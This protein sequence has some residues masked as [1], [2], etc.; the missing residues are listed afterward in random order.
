MYSAFGELTY[1]RVATFG[2]RVSTARV[3]Q[4]ALEGQTADCTA[5]PPLLDAAAGRGGCDG[6][7]QRAKQR[8]TRWT[9]CSPPALLSPS[10]S[11]VVSPSPSPQAE[12]GNITAVEWSTA[13]Y[14][15]AAILGLEVLGFFYLGEVIGRG[16]LIGYPVGP[17]GWT[18]KH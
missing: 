12:L 7:Q 1:L 9:Q 5:P 14:G 8:R 2:Q 16:N 6:A 15:R 18:E 4:R 13:A 3:R 17:D 10:V 11:F